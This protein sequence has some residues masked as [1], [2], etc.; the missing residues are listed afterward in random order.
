VRKLACSLLAAAGLLAANAARADIN[1]CNNWTSPIWISYGQVQW[2]DGAK[3]H[4]GDMTTDEV[5]GWWHPSPGE[6]ATVEVGCVCNWWANVWGNC[7]ESDL[8]YY[9]E[10]D[11]GN[12]W[13]GN[14]DWQTC[15]PWP[16]FDQCDGYVTSCPDGRW[17]T[18]GVWDYDSPVC[19]LTLT[20]G[21]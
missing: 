2:Y 12:W 13:G 16:A 8:H 17:L 4:V 14:Q 9:A 7:P 18:W 6:C 21:Q 15:T 10:D 3:C 19:N 11:S 5:V 1:L 20:F